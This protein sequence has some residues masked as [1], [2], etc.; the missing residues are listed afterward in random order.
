M[1]DVI[2]NIFIPFGIGFL[3]GVI[4]TLLDNKFRKK[5]LQNETQ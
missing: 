1:I 2:K 5:K 3:L 4:W